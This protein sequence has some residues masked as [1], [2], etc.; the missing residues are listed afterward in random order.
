MAIKN[1]KNLLRL[2]GNN[3]RCDEEFSLLYRKKRLKKKISKYTFRDFK[4]RKKVKYNYIG[5]NTCISVTYINSKKE[6]NV[7]QILNLSFIK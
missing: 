7:T 1:K 4:Y 3:R 5:N 6:E 2:K